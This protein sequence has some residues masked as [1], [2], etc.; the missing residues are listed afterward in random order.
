MKKAWILALAGSLAACGQPADTPADGGGSTPAPLES[1]APGADMPDSEPI[2]SPYEVTESAPDDTDYAALAGYPDTWYVS[3]G[4]PGEYPAGFVVLEQGVTVNGRARPNP[5]APANVA[6]TL[7]Q[8][9]NYQIWNRKR[10]EHDHLEFIVASKIEPVVM[11]VD[12]NI[13]TPGDEGMQVLELK[14]GDVLSYLRYLGEGFAIFRVNGQEY[15]I[16]EAELRDI[17]SMSA[18]SL[19]EDQ[20]VEVACIGGKRAWLLYDDAIAQDDIVPSPIVGFGEA[21]DIYPDEVDKVRAEGLE[22]EAFQN[23]ALDEGTDE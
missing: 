13:E 18:V 23:G 12:A 21:S 7:P 3:Y 5:D 6:C 8:Y 2:A 22:L 9:A 19:E 17:S 20:W 1:E 15:T 11:Q 4:W 14:A 10:V 16:N